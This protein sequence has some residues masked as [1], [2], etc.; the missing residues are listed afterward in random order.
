[1]NPFMACS[2]RVQLQLRRPQHAHRKEENPH[3][4][5]ASV[6]GAPTSDCRITA[7]VASCDKSSASVHAVQTW[8]RF[9][10]AETV[11]CSGGSM[12]KEGE[13]MALPR[14]QNVLLLPRIMGVHHGL[15]NWCAL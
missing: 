10:T 14:V 9:Y 6:P 2:C 1:M 5:V 4:P 15:L 12:M 8:L 11:H 7:E 3:A 13:I